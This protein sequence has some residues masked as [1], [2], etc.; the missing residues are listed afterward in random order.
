MSSLLK[1]PALHVAAT[2]IGAVMLSGCNKDGGHRPAASLE[3]TAAGQGTAATAR[4]PA[5]KTSTGQ[6]KQL[7]I[8]GRDHD[9]KH[10][11]IDCPLRKAGINPHE[12]KPF[13]D[14]DK[15]I[16][17]LDR[18]DRAGWQKPD[19]V[20]T[21][22]GLT[23]DETVADVGA[24]SGYFTFRL[25]RALPR[26]KVVAIDVE[27]EMVRHLHHK[28]KREGIKNIEVVLGKVD[29][30]RVPSRTDIVFICDVLHHVKDRSTWLKNL[31]AAIKGGTRVVLIEF[32]EGKLPEGPP[33]SV[34]IPKKEMV[35]LARA[36]G[37]RLVGE[38]KDLLPYQTYLEF[39]KPPP[40]ETRP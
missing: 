37:L 20:V 27:P 19:V 30:P 33:E 24:G 10:P 18:A 28:A 14:V 38:K 25:A 39:N 32:R 11:P 26:G 12:L 35:A 4:D 31:A 40:G 2:L 34:K 9:P 7:V 15:Y 22:L 1:S 23:G 21:A 3:S 17:F 8:E 29:D 36:A 16:K 6:G 5:R 13:G